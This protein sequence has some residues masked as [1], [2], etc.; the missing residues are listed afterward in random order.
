MSEF[1]KILGNILQSNP[2]TAS[3]IL[4]IC[5]ILIVLRDIIPIKAI[6]KSLKLIKDPLYELLKKLDSKIETL[7]LNHESN[8]ITLLNMVKMI[9]DKQ[10]SYLTNDQVNLVT[11]L[12]F[13]YIQS[14][15]TLKFIEIGNNNK[16]EK[17]LEHLIRSIFTTLITETDRLYFQLPNTHGKVLVTELK[18]K[19]FF[20][21]DRDGS[22][23]AER[24]RNVLLNNSD[25]TSKK[26]S[27]LYDLNELTSK[28]FQT[29]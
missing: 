25:Y 16:N 10:N 24:I 11:S 15:L 2:E 9:S 13:Q 21:G 7:I 27:I 12:T 6:L 22:S 4:I 3:V 29:I 18:I 1:Y 17:E 14:D 20:N 28:W 5:F 8:S 19:T 26:A 23:P